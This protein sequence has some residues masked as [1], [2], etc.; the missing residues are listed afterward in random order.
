M[1]NRRNISIPDDLDKKLDQ[2]HLNASGLIQDL[3]RGYFAYS[4]VDAAVEFT[5]DKRNEDREQRLREMCEALVGVVEGDSGKLDRYNEGVLNW[6]S[7]LEIPPET[8]VD[9]V[10]DYAETGEVQVE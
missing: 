2:P 6:A 9:I 7:R 1:S 4:D 5:A 10:E 8:I 3:L